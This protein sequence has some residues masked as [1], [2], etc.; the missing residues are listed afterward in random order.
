MIKGGNIFTLIILFAYSGNIS[1]QFAWHNVE[2]EVAFRYGFNQHRNDKIPVSMLVN[3]I[4]FA[5]NY[6][7]ITTDGNKI[8]IPNYTRMYAL[9]FG[10][11]IFFTEN[12]FIRGNMGVQEQFFGYAADY[13]HPR[14]TAAVSARVKYFGIP[15]SLGGGYSIPFGW[16]KG[17]SNVGAFN[18]YISGFFNSLMSPRGQSEIFLNTVDSLNDGRQFND[19][20]VFDGIQSGRMRS[21]TSIFG[22][23]FGLSVEFNEIT[24]SFEY[25]RFAGNSVLNANPVNDPVFLQGSRTDWYGHSLEFGVSFRFY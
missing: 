19:F 10:L 9:D 14:G 5:D 20:T 6:A 22:G 7:P 21:I 16:G 1:G 24:F 8:F 23:L 3:D 12:W 17:S 13:E 2:K 15:L 4:N 25:R 18:V 11:R